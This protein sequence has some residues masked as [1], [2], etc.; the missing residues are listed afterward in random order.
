MIQEDFTDITVPTISSN[1]QGS[2]VVESFGV[3]LS[4]QAVVE[5][6]LKKLL[7]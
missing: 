3:R 4:Y 2:P 7:A 1:M 6:G 5:F